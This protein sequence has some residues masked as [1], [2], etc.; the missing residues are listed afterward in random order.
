MK[1]LIVH[2]E[3]Y[4]MFSVET[5][6]DDDTRVDKVIEVPDTLVER[7]RKA[8]REFGEVQDELYDLWRDNR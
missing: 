3:W 6:W 8:S 5:D 7:Y 2:S 4:P 1:A